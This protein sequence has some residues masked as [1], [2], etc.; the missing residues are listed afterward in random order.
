[1]KLVSFDDARVGVMSDESV[2]DITDLVAGP[3]DRPEARML[4]LIER[5]EVLQ[6]ECDS[7]R[8]AKRPALPLDDVRL[9]VPLSSPSKIIGAPVNYLAHQGEMNLDV[10]VADLGVFLKASSSVIGPGGLVQLPYLDRRTDQEGELAVVIGD[11]AR[12]VSAANALEHV[13]G[14][15][16]LLDITLRGGEDRSTRKS[17]DTFTPLGPWIATADEVGDPSSLW[18]RCWVNEELRQEANTRQLIVGVPELIAYVSSIM[19]LYP[20]D[21]V[22]TG[23]P[24]GVGP[25]AH[26]D[27]IAVEIDR[28]GRLEVDVSAEAAVPWEQARLR[29]DVLAKA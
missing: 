13:F 26:G 10:T 12:N 7:D 17:F 28:I 14:Y 9:A 11:L 4:S 5:W 2:L 23:S 21:I 3:L 22:A 27:R 18:L 20:G 1:M 6:G 8:L 15:T 25:L 24:A 29:P 19:T 16:C